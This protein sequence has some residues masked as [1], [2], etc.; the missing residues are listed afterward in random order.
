MKRRYWTTQEIV[1]LRSF[2]RDAKT[3]DL[4]VYFGRPSASVYVKAAALG[5]HKSQRFLA[6]Q[7]SGR[8]QRGRTHPAMIATQFKPGHTSWNKGTHY[9]AGGRSAETRFKPG[10]ISKRWDIEEYSVGALR[11]NSD[12]GLDI[13]YRTGPRA[14]KPLAR[15]VWETEIGPI[16]YG[17]SVRARNGDR[18][19]TRVENLYL[20]PRH[21]LMQENTVHNYPKPVAR[22]IQ[23][24]GAIRRQVNRIVKKAEERA[25]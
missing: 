21:V 17:M 1:A 3:A 16:P 14:W 11:I 2:Y 24:K 7:A 4:A 15:F 12:G 10:N 25:A 13:K 18:D 22:L 9:V 19:D 8:I 5:L 6:S 23:L 20:C